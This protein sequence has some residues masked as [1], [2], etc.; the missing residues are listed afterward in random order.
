MAQLPLIRQNQAGN[1]HIDGLKMAQQ[2]QY[3]L[4]M[5]QHKPETDPKFNLNRTMLRLGLK[6]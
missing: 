5:A 3:S 6:F 2:S 1:A 4:Q